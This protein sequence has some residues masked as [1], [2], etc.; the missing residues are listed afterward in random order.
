VDDDTVQLALILLSE[1][2]GISAHGV[3]T[4]EE[5]ATDD[6]AFGVVE[7]NDVGVVIVLQILAVHFQNPFVVAEDVGYVAHT[8][9]VLS[10]NGLDPCIVFAFLD[11]GEAYSL[12]LIGNHFL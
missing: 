10:R 3:E 6:F 1:L 2:L 4:D 7:G 9:P 12:G 11:G 5:V 8:L